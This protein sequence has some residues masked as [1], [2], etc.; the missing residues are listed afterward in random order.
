MHVCKAAGQTIFFKLDMEAQ[1]V[2]CLALSASQSSQLISQ[3][4]RGSACLPHGTRIQSF[5]AT[6]VLCDDVFEPPAQQ[7]RLEQHL[8]ALPLSRKVCSCMPEGISVAAVLPRRARHSCR[9][10]GL[11]WEMALEHIWPR[12]H[13]TRQLQDN[14]ETTTRQPTRQPT[15]QL[16][17]WCKINIL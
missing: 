6:F 7:A 4:G 16:Q 13:S 17:T 15:R 14:Y 11:G 10:P 2:P 12:R 3:Y 5:L 8:Y 9:C 1:T